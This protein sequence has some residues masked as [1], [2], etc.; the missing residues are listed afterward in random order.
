MRFARLALTVVLTLILL[1]VSSFAGGKPMP[2]ADEMV[3]NGTAGP[4]PESVKY[5]V[6]FRHMAALEKKAA[7][8]EKSG[9]DGV[10]YRTLVRASARLTDTQ[11]AQLSSIAADCLARVEEK[12]RE[13]IAIIRAARALTPRGRL[14]K[15][16]VAPEPPAE[17]KRLQAERDEI[18]D[19]AR[20]DL[21]RAFGDKE[22]A[23]F[24][25]FVDDKIAPT[26]RRQ[27]ANLKDVAVPQLPP[28][29]SKGGR[30]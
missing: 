22:F 16:A 30:P 26:I 9:G 8:V 14:E 23:R 7:A 2:A 18:L 15:D 3:R 25:G 21:H 12:D 28:A 10:P 20:A 4:L 6:L 13:A 5:W 24:Q 19:A 17:L 27:Q 29:G 1:P 11:A